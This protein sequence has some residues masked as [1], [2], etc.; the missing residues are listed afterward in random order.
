MGLIRREACTDVLGI[1]PDVLITTRTSATG[2]FIRCSIPVRAKVLCNLTARA[3][4]L[5]SCPTRTNID[6]VKTAWTLIRVTARQETL[7]T[8]CFTANTFIPACLVASIHPDFSAWA[9]I[10][11][12]RFSIL[13][14]ITGLLISSSSCYTA[15]VFSTSN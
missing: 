9:G 2:A 6:G 7:I 8:G 1:C 15:S 5:W 14:P 10:R 13:T 3:F 12:V 4:I 11:I